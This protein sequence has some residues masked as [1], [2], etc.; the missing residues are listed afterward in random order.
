MIVQR[1]SFDSSINSLL[2]YWHSKVYFD[3]VKIIYNTINLVSLN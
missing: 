2:H 3:I 1:I